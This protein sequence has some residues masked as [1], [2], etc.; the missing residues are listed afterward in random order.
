MRHSL[1]I[2]E[3]AEP[4]AEHSVNFPAVAAVK[5]V[6]AAVKPAAFAE[7]PAAASSPPADQ[8]A[9]PWLFAALSSVSEVPAGRALLYFLCAFP[10]SGLPVSL[11]ALPVFPACQQD[12][13]LHFPALPAVVV[14]AVVGFYFSTSVF[15]YSFPTRWRF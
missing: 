13:H 6:A 9:L 7:Q 4:V 12:A 10:Y 5:P 15:E 1:K 3:P 14:P 11:P 2:V 8:P